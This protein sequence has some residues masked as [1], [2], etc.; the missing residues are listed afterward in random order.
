[1]GTPFE[2][3]TEAS[4]HAIWLGTNPGKSVPFGPA[5]GHD[6][7]AFR[8]H[9]SGFFGNGVSGVCWDTSQRLWVATDGPI[10]RG[11]VSGASAHFERVAPPGSEEDESFLNV[12]QKTETAGPLV[13]S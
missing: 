3:I 9:E 4:D 13:W 6:L 12:A 2:P 11:L 8:A 10:Y 5:H 7:G 1:M